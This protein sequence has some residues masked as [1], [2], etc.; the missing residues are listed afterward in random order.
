MAT[1]ARRNRKIVRNVTLRVYQPGWRLCPILLPRELAIRMTS[2]L[3][4]VLLMAVAAECPLLPAPDYAEQN[5][6]RGYIGYV[7][8]PSFFPHEP[9]E[10]G[11]PRVDVF[12]SPGRG[13]R[14]AQLWREKK[15]GCQATV[16]A[17]TN[18][19]VS[20]CPVP[21]CPMA[22]MATKSRHSLF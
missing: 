20:A 21:C 17:A 19:S 18:D 5:L 11:E 15:Q 10:T 2:L 16:H 6:Y 22:N 13:R 7:S 9:C 14:I 1:L 12:V 3:S 8:F 4:L